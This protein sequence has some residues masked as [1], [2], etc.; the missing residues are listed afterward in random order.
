[1]SFLNPSPTVPERKA[2]LAVFRALAGELVTTARNPAYRLHCR[3]RSDAVKIPKARASL[4][5]KPTASKRKV[6]T[7]LRGSGGFPLLCCQSLLSPRIDA[8]FNQRIESAG[9]TVAV[10]QSHE[11]LQF[12]AYV[13]ERGEMCVG[14]RDFA[15]W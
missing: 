7:Y 3:G 15:A 2:P 1:M 10:G 8:H 12:V 14:A 13:H 5:N 4:K 9:Q 11:G 6:N